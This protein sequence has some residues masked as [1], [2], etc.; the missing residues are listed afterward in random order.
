MTRVIIGAWLWS[1][2]HM[3][4]EMLVVLGHDSVLRNTLGATQ[5]LLGCSRGARDSRGLNGLA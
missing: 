3:Q 5:K 4:Y 1:M 2:C